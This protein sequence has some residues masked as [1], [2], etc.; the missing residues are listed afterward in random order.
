MAFLEQLLQS[1]GHR[2]Q[3][4]EREQIRYQVIVFNELTLLVAHVLADHARA[5]E[6]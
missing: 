4:V 2:Y 1:L 6:T 3:R 5:A